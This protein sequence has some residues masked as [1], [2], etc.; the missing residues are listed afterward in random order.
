MYR[1]IDNS[2]RLNVYDMPDEAIRATRVEMSAAEKKQF[3][4]KYIKTMQMTIADNGDVIM[5]FKRR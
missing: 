4:S 5:E 2:V 1:Y 3:K